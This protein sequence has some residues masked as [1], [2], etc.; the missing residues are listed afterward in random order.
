MAGVAINSIED[1]RL[2]FDCIPLDKVSVSI[3]MNGAV[4]NFMTM[5]KA[6][7]GASDGSRSG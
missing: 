6:G 1:V 4:L 2:L 3:T 5:Y 7:S